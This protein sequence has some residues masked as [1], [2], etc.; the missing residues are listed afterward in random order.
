MNEY[1]TK[2]TVYLTQRQK[3]VLQR[4]M[5]Y[6][7]SSIIRDILDMIILSD[8]LIDPND[9]NNDPKIL[10]LLYEYRRYLEL[11]EEAYKNRESLRNNLYSYFNEMRIP[12]ICARW[13]HR[14]A[15]KTCRELIPEFRLGGYSIS[16]RVAESMIVDYVHMIEDTGMDDRAWMDVQKNANANPESSYS[17]DDSGLLTNRGVLR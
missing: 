4:L 12:V 6:K 9:F 3:E 17:D 11:S 5:P 7:L 1:Y 14:K 15:L 13:G 2:S 10:G 8:K 16:D